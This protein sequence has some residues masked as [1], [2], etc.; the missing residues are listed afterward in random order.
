MRILGIFI[1][2]GLVDF[3]LIIPTIFVGVIFHY[4]RVFYLPTSRSFKRLE[5]VGNNGFLS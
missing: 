3:Y 5:G 4:I 2:V 1:V